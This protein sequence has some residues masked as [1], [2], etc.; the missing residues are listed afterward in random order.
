MIKVILPTN[1]TLPGS[2]FFHKITQA[3]TRGD[4]LMYNDDYTQA[5]LEL[6]TNKF[7]TEEDAKNIVNAGGEV[8]GFGFWIEMDKSKYET[9]SI[10][11]ELYNILFASL[12]NNT[13]EEKDEEEPTIGSY[14]TWK[15]IFPFFE[16][17]GN[18]EEIEEG[19][20][21]SSSSS[22]HTKIKFLTSFQ[23]EYLKASI[24]VNSILP[25]V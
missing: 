2:Q 19:S 21:T 20:D 9:E 18:Q 15:Q 7:F 10:S 13:D 6:S 22:A 11:E 16:F 24:V 14:P 12:I 5:T 1:E 23:S 17:S 4:F 25:L 3:S 8:E